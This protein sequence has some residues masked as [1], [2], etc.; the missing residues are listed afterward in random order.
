M[1]R[2]IR[3]FVTRCMVFT[4]LGLLTACSHQP[5]RVDCEKRL[6]PINAATAAAAKKPKVEAGDP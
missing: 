3:R 6:E 1:N 2:V 5:K 4:A